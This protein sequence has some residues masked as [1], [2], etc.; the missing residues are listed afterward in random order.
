MTVRRKGRLPALV[1]VA[2]MSGFVFG[3]VAVGADTDTAPIQACVND[4]T[5]LVR[6]VEGPSDCRSNEDPLAWA[7]QGLPGEPGPTGRQ[8]PEGPQGEPGPSSPGDAWFTDIQVPTTLSAGSDYH[9]IGALTV[10]P[11]NYTLAATVS[12]FNSSAQ[13]PGAECGIQMDG[14]N[15]LLRTTRLVA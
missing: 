14:L 15:L 3:A 6:V 4:R 8:G 10:P 9:V 7:R 2:L 12:L 11:G 5:G 1:A 13:R